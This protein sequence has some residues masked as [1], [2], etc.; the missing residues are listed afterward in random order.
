MS[1]SEDPLVGDQGATAVVV[2][3][4]ANLVLKGH[5]GRTNDD[6][7]WMFSDFRKWTE[8]TEFKGGVLKR[9]TCQGQL[10]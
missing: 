2:E 6:S 8:D 10:F 7:T 9:H 1:S 4:A 5:L 3:V